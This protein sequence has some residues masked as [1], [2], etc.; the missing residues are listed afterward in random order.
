MINYD[1]TFVYNIRVGGKKLG[2]IKFYLVES[3]RK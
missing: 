1:Y 3:S 2:C